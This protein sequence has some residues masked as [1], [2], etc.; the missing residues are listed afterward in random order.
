MELRGERF[1]EPLEAVLT[2]LKSLAEAI[3]DATSSNAARDDAE[4]VD[5]LANA[6]RALVETRAQLPRG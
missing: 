5:R 1:D 6:A 4:V 2:S 3:P